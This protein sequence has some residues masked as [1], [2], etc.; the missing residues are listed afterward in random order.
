MSNCHT[1]TTAVT[2]EERCL[3]L[4]LKEATADFQHAND[5][6]QMWKEE[7]IEECDTERAAVIDDLIAR[8]TEQLESLA[9]CPRWYQVL[10]VRGPHKKSRGPH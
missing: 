2:E 3:G 7:A 1:Q 9:D 6:L 10:M 8:N 5:L 4:N